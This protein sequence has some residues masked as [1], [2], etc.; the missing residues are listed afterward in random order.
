[1]ALKRVQETILTLDL[2]TF[3]FA[4]VSEEP[5]RF[6]EKAVWKCEYCPRQFKI[7]RDGRLTKPIQNHIQTCT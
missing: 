5:V 1:M 2:S 4:S 6:V 7:G 3:D